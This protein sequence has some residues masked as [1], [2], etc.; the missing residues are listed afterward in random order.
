VPASDGEPDDKGDETDAGAAPAERIIARG[1]LWTVCGIGLGLVLLALAC[2]TFGTWSNAAIVSTGFTG[3]T[4]LQ[5]LDAFSWQLCA[6]AL[7]VGMATL[8]G[9]AIVR[10][11]VPRG[12]RGA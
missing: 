2:A 5:M 8:V 1:S 9:A 7:L 3:D 12:G 11:L 6:P 4:T 10:V